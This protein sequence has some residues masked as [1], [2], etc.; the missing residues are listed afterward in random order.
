MLTFLTAKV[1]Y[2]IKKDTFIM[3]FGNLKKTIHIKTIIF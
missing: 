3:E 1:V 2:I